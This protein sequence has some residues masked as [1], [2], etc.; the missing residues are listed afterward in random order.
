MAFE[1]VVWMAAGKAMQSIVAMALRKV[2][3]MA[4]EKERSIADGKVVPLV[5]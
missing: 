4:G 2:D 5:G 1:L 3:W